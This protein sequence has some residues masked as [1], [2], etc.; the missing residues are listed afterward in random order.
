MYQG[1]SP[2]CASTIKPMPIKAN[3]PAPTAPAVVR[4][5]MALLAF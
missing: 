5:R 2:N 3:E 4:K 1:L